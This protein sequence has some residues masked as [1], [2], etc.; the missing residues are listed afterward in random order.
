LGLGVGEAGESD[1]QHGKR[2]CEW[3]S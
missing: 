1:R 3:I 2:G